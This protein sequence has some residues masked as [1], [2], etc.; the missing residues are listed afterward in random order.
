MTNTPVIEIAKRTS[1][2]HVVGELLHRQGSVVSATT[3]QDKKIGSE[4]S[5]LRCRGY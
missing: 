1:G 3:P 2:Q 5:P 4:P